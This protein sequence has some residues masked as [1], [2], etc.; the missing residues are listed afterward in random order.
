VGSTG[1]GR[2][3]AAAQLQA[4]VSLVSSAAADRGWGA[5]PVVR[6]CRG[7][8]VQVDGVGRLDAA[9]V[10]QAARGLIGALIDDL[11]AVTGADLA[12]VV[13]PWLTA[14]AV[15][16]AEAS[17]STSDRHTARLLSGQGPAA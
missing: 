10:F 6:P 9:E 1:S 7:G 11:V 5:E 3:P 13:S 17:W 12:D 4:A 8:R 16:E 14:L 15:Q 2:Q